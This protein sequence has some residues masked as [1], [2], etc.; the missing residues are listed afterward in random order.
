[1]PGLHMREWKNELT[2]EVTRKNSARGV[3]MRICMCE[4]VCA[5]L[6]Y[7]SVCKSC[8]LFAYCMCATDAFVL[9]WVLAAHQKKDY[10]DYRVSIMVAHWQLN[11]VWAELHCLVSTRVALSEWMACTCRLALDVA[12]ER[13]YVLNHS[14][15]LMTGCTHAH[16][17]RASHKLH[18]YAAAFSQ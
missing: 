13:A 16:R 2:A 3:C 1:M 4:R 10:K 15:A 7:V 5:L 8:I 18:G 11:R 12:C 14:S 6:L 17:L 9:L